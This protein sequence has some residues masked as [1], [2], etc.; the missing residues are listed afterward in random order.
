MASFAWLGA[1]L[2]E[3]VCPLE[4]PTSTHANASAVVIA[5]MKVLTLGVIANQTFRIRLQRQ[6]Y[7]SVILLKLMRMGKGN[8]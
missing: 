6:S 7:A 2:L 3:A 5:K 4:H 1:E 8:E